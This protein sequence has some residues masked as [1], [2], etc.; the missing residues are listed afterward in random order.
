M[1]M[2]CEVPM[3]LSWLV[4]KRC[5]FWQQAAR[6]CSKIWQSKSNGPVETGLG[7]GF[8]CWIEEQG[9]T[10]LSYSRKCRSCKWR[11]M[12]C[13][14]VWWSEAQHQNLLLQH[15][16]DWDS[17]S[18]RSQGGECQQIDG[19]PI[20]VAHPGKAEKAAPD[21]LPKLPIKSAC[22]ALLCSPWGKRCLLDCLSHQLVCISSGWKLKYLTIRSSSLQKD[23]T[24]C[25]SQHTHPSSQWNVEIEC[26]HQH[27]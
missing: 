7:L 13:P 21:L 20:D 8:D 15:S 18:Q 25:C 17:W 3:H 5:G 14:Q 10:L 12:C 16:S 23:A 1:H 26:I 24:C 2:Q 9:K 19:L 22:Q 4:Q 11:K 27:I 6:D